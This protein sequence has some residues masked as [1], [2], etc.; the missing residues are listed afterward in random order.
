MDNNSIY[1]KF[2]EFKGN[3]SDFAIEYLKNNY[4]FG[5]ININDGAKTL[6]NIIDKYISNVNA[7]M[8]QDDIKAEFEK[9]LDLYVNHIE[10]FDGEE[11]KAEDKEEVK[12]AI[13]DAMINKSWIKTVW[14]K[15]KKVLNINED[16]SKEDSSTIVASLDMREE[17]REVM[18]HAFRQIEIAEV[19]NKIDEKNTSGIE[20]QFIFEAFFSPIGS[21]AEMVLQKICAVD[22]LCLQGQVSEVSIFMY[23]KIS[24]LKLGLIEAVAEAALMSPTEKL[25]NN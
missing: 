17:Q 22:I 13:K 23:D 24:E 7:M 2:D 25:E 10:T 20:Y 6:W 19:I 8:A 1:K 3:Y 11:L 5:N 15:L 21:E 16:I 14:K 12:A 4:N 9:E 18:E